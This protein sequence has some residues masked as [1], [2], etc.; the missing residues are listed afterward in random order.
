[1]TPME[2]IT[3]KR[4]YPKGKCLGYT[5]PITTQPGRRVLRLYLYWQA[6]V[7]IVVRVR[8]A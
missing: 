5:I 6:L 1:M 4:R 3:G 8:I 2:G 7:L